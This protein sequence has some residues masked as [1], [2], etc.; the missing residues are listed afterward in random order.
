M[1]R[2]QDHA[3]Q[4]GLVGQLTNSSG[5]NPQGQGCDRIH[6]SSMAKNGSGLFYQRRLGHILIIAKT[7]ERLIDTRFK[8]TVA[9]VKNNKDYIVSKQRT[10]QVY[11]VNNP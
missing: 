1:K 9:M 11:S 10:Q 2:S 7:Q 6:T 3:D 4:A 8:L 5:V